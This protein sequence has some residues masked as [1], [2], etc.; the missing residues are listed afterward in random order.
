MTRNEILDI[1]S[2]IYAPAA[3][4]VGSEYWSFLVD[5]SP[6]TLIHVYEA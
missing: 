2:S 4:R 6:A 1:L 5:A 3:V